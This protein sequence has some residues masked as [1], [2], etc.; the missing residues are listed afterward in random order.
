MFANS[1]R[2]VTMENRIDT[3]LSQ[4]YEIEGLMLVMQRR[5]NELPEHLLTQFMAK[6]DSLKQQASDLEKELTN[7]MANEEPEVIISEPAAV[8]PIPTIEPETIPEIKP[9][10]ETKPESKTETPITPPVAPVAVE[11]KPARDIMSAFSINDRFL[12]LRELFDGDE[13]CF[14]EAIAHMQHM[15]NINQVHNFMTD[16]LEWDPSNDV[17]KEFS[18]IVGTCYK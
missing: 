2:F 5:H 14:N 1:K 7:S 6:I 12:F 18:R 9:E 13:Q 4:L 11:P 3:L 17:V 16:I 10:P 15:N 8:G